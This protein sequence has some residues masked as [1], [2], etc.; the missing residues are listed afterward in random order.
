MSRDQER[1]YRKTVTSGDLIPFQIAVKE[2][3]LWVSA[4]RVLQKETLDLVFHCR[5][6][7][8]S[9]IHIHSEFAT[10]MRPWEP[11]PYAP[12]LVREMI[13]VS[14]MVGVGPMAA[15]AG[16][17]AQFVG[18]GLLQFT[19]QVIVE[20]G[21]DVFLKARRP[22]RI[23][24]LAGHSPLSGRLGLS[25]PPDDMPL[26]VCSSSGTLGHS[27]S[28]GIADTVCVVAA[29]AALGDGTAT[30]LGNRIK[31][32]TDLEA[33]A[34][35]AKGIQGVRGGVAIVGDQMVTWGDIQLVAL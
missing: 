34:N 3:D 9:Y 14:G 5:H 29:S 16:A 8:E 13:R 33:A 31:R 30:A 22:V 12:P 23:S 7:L 11:D 21:G 28:M 19:D 25:V 4:E 32:K 26:G 15:V 27:L 6:A 2:T 24:I 20:N 1:S 17:I 35:W 10:S 18:Q